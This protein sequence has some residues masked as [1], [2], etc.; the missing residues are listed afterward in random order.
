MLAL[1]VRLPRT[2]LLAATEPPADAVAEGA[3]LRR[4]AMRALEVLAVT[5]HADAQRTLDE[6]RERLELAF[7]AVPSR[8]AAA[9]PAAKTAGTSAHA[10]TR[11]RTLALTRTRTRTRTLTRRHRR[12]G[13]LR[14]QGRAPD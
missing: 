2:Y 8:P 7:A 9:A 6:L 12:G 13:C 10:L 5:P 3:R 4:D 14:S 11:T 1:A